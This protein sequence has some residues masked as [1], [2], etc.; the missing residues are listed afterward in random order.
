MSEGEDDGGWK[1]AVEDL[2]DEA[3]DST[4]GDE[5]PGDEEQGEDEG[6][7]VAGSMVL[8][9]PLEPGSPSLENTAFV[10]LGALCTVVFFMLLLGIL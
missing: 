7:N 2:P 9:Q 4:D 8:E 3:G 6:G 10:L 5:Q 1:F